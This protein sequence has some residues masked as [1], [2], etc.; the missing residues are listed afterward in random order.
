M[1]PLGALLG[2]AMT[3]VFAAGVDVDDPVDCMNRL[4]KIIW[5]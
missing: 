1:A 2:L 3:G 5:I 4:K